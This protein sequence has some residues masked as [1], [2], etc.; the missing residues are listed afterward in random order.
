MYS[1][2][3]SLCMCTCVRACVCSGRSRQQ[4]SGRNFS[5]WKILWAG[6]LGCSLIRFPR[7]GEHCRDFIEEVAGVSA[8]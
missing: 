8:S 3:V 1:V 5:E 4:R 6:H 2:C 7:R